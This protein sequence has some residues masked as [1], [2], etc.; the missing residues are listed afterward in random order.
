MLYFLSGGDSDIRIF[1]H[2]FVNIRFSVIE[3]PVF[4]IGMPIIAENDRN[5]A[6]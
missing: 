1:R 3:I 4:M 6:V 2:F 5:T